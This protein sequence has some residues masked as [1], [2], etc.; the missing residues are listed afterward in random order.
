[1]DCA[2]YLNHTGVML[3]DH[4]RVAASYHLNVMVGV[5]VDA[6]QSEADCSA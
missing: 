4:H 5:F 3:G 6:I 2:R 1:M